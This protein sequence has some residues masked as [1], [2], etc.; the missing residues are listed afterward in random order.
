MRKMSGQNNK[1]EW[2][3]ELEDEFQMMKKYVKQHMKLSLLN[4]KRTFIFIVTPDML[5]FDIFLASQL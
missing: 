2:N 4:V 5:A 3:Q 1:F